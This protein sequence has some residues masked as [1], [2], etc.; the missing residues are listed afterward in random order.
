V[1]RLCVETTFA[2]A[3]A[4]LIGQQ[5]E[6]NHGHNWHV[7]VTLEGERLDGDGLLIDFHAVEALLAEVT[8]PFRN[9]DLNRTPPFDS[10]NPSAENVARHIAEAMD[11]KTREGRRGAGR[12]GRVGPGDRGAR[13]LCG[14]RGPGLARGES[15]MNPLPGGIPTTATTTPAPSARV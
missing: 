7:T 11:R 2:A 3:H 12:A 4:L 15:F 8:G 9:A 5:R 14:V 6:P 10:L 13:L 1:F